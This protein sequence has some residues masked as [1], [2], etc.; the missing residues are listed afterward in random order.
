MTQE[1]ILSVKNLLE[2]IINDGSNIDNNFTEK[3]E[4]ISFRLKYNDPIL[5]AE[6]TPPYLAT[7]NEYQESVYFAY[8][9]LSGKKEDLRYLTNEEKDALSLKFKIEEGSDIIDVM[10]ENSDKLITLIGGKMDGT[11]ILI[12]IIVLLGYLSLD[13]IKDIISEIN[14]SKKDNLNI[15]REKKLYETIE[16]I[17]EKISNNYSYL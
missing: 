8:L 10:S 14:S 6:L 1:K 9:A 16:K 7:L 4:K 15:E 2:Q 5:K 12:F 3:L 13:K 11:Q 17:S